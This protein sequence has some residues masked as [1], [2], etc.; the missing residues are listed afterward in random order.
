MTQSLGGRGHLTAATLIVALTACASAA[1]RPL[2]LDQRLAQ[3]PAVPLLC[4][5]MDPPPNDS[6]PLAF[7]FMD[8]PDGMSRAIIAGFDSSG[9]PRYLVIAG[10]IPSGEQSIKEHR[11]LAVFVGAQIVAEAEIVSDATSG[12]PAELIRITLSDTMSHSVRA[13]GDRLWKIKCR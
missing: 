4:T 9:A 3:P 12:A 10:R 7:R 8:S 1:A 6:A 13:L 5:K 11:L 2:M